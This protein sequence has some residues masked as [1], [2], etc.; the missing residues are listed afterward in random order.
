MLKFLSIVQDKGFNSVFRSIT[1]LVRALSKVATS[2]KIGFL[3]ESG[4]GVTISEDKS[5]ASGVQDK[6]V[7]GERFLTGV[8]YYEISVEKL[9][10]SLKL[11]I[12]DGDNAE[13]TY[14]YCSDGS[15]SMLQAASSAAG[16][17]VNDHIGILVDFPNSSLAF[18]KNKALVAGP[19]RFSM[20]SALVYCAFAGESSVKFIS[21]DYPTTFPGRLM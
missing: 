3:W 10:G 9:S 18:Y 16:L 7:V 4:E 13:N 21:P 1:P 5:S 8:R 6:T 15:I 11:G 19:T 12:R 2:R 20:T 14:W 17:A